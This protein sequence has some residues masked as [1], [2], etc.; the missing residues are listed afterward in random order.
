[1][2]FNI[3]PEPEYERELAKLEK[4]YKKALK[5]IIKQLKDVDPHD[6][7][8]QSIYESQIRQL[9]YIIHELNNEALSWIEENLTDAFSHAQASALVT[10]GL[11][12]DIVEAKGELKFSLMSQHRMEAIISDTFNDVLKAH[13]V[14]EQ[15]LKQLVRDVQAEVLRENFIMQRG[16]TSSA[17]ELRSALLKEGFS[18]TLIEEEWKGIIDASGRRWDLT[19]YV[20]TVAKTKLQQ[21]QI[22]G[23]RLQSLE[24]END[25]AII[26]DHGAKDACRFF[27]GM[28]ISLEGKTR[29]FKTL[30]ELRNSHLIFHPNC[31]HIVHP[32]GDIDALPKSIREAASKQ[33]R[34]AEKA[35]ENPQKI[36]REDNARRYKEAKKK[37]R[38]RK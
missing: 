33:E 26:S 29:G 38:R 27:E 24:N 7:L 1:M 15:N 31:R 10:L 37:R 19:T 21:T 34:E 22:E 30:T 18:E 14:M 23:A 3:P 13:S 4:Y 35:L 8:T 16:S 32:I 2:A 5:R 28:I 9:T 11:A 12:K 17:R 25:L 20:K 6:L 36:R